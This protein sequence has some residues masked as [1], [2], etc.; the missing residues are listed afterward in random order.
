DS[1]KRHLYVY[2]GQ[3]IALLLAIPLGYVVYG[4]STHQLH[5]DKNLNFYWM[6]ADS[7]QQKSQAEFQIAQQKTVEDQRNLFFSSLRLQSIQ[8]YTADQ[9]GASYGNRVYKT[10]FS[11][12]KT[13]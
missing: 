2:S 7:Y 3:F 5:V 13:K 10:T 1:W 8:L 11:R 4:L 9:G 6:D 12:A